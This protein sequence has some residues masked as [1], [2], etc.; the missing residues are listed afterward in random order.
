MRSESE[1]FSAKNIVMEYSHPNIGK[2]MGVHHLLSTVIGDAIKRSYRE[3]GATVVADNFIGDLGT[4][5]GKLIHA[6]KSWGDLEKIELDPITELLKL[7][8]QFH[9]E[10]E[11]DVELDDAARVEYKKLEDGDPENRALWQKIIGWS[12]AEIQPIY[13]ELDVEFDY[14][15]GES[16]YEK[17]LPGIID[18]GV[19]KDIFVESQGALVY[20][21]KNPDLPP[22]IVRKKDGAT[23]YLTRDLARIEYWEQTWHPDLMI[24]VVDM[25]QSLHFQQV[26]EVAEAMELTDAQNVHVGFGRMQF[27]DSSMSTRK[28]NILLLHDLIDE[29]KKRARELVDSKTKDLTDDEKHELTEVLAIGSLK[30]NIL[31]QNRQSNITF[32]WSKMLTF[33]GNSAPYLVYSTVR[34]RS[35]AQKAA[36]QT[37]EVEQGNSRTQFSDLEKQL[38]LHLSKFPYAVKESLAEYRPNAIA[39]YLYGLAQSYNSFYNTVEFLKASQADR[40]R[41]LQLNQLFIEIMSSGLQMLGIEIP[42]KM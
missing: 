37:A 25:A 3:I 12:K 34:A 8:V 1:E 36:Q 42:T 21:M 33:E 28:G 26:F 9:I 39:N 29:A 11:S 16:F 13:D 31:S 2:P 6:V 32:D 14:M 15:N 22:A 23:L 20:T 41:R 5:F 35:I 10:A 30:Y 17:A 4:Q 18:Q 27:A 24:V 7:Y 19:K 40:E 38:A